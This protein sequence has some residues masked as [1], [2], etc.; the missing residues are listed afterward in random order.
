MTQVRLDASLLIA[1]ADRPHFQGSYNLLQERRDPSRKLMSN[2]TNDIE[3]C[4][5][6][7]AAASERAR[8]PENLGS[9]GIAEGNFPP[10]QE[11]SYS[12]DNLIGDQD[13]PRRPL[14]KSL[15]NEALLARWIRRR[16]A[17][18]R[19]AIAERKA[20]KARQHHA[21][22]AEQLA[23]QSLTVAEQA[24]PAFADV[25]ISLVQHRAEEF[26]HAATGAP[27]PDFGLSEDLVTRQTK[28]DEA[29]EQ[30]ITAK[31]LHESLV[32][33]LSHADS[34]VRLST[35]QVANAAI[36]V[37]V[38]E[39]VKQATELKAAWNGAWRQYDQL[40]ALADCQLHC[41]EASSTITLPRDA[42]TLLETMAALDERARADEGIYAASAGE[43][44][45]RWFTALLT[46][47]DAEETFET[48][49]ALP[50]S[51]LKTKETRLDQL[52]QVLHECEN[53]FERFP[54]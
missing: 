10:R 2:P 37:L 38:A 17:A 21:E 46:D 45:C 20:A 48:I 28:P 29:R 47:A 52:R 4:D 25:D 9:A 30:V 53:I 42:I 35:R 6:D 12:E 31:A 15:L 49:S 43:V 14:D 19:R 33:D 54:T 40:C 36:D 39:A 50:R 32:A 44:W 1:P 18:L 24:L 41:A 7:L 34:A 13:R 26:K 23:R 16:R 8:D 3:K 51:W 11:Q 22:Q 27:L 5:S